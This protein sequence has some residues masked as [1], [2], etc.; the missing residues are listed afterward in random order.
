MFAA[1]PVV[2]I[3]YISLFVFEKLLNIA[4]L[5]SFILSVIPYY[6][7]ILFGF[8]V[9]GGAHFSKEKKSVLLGIFAISLIYT[10]YFFL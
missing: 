7:F 4:M 5:S 8:S 9:E 3:S 2:V 10:T 6:L 1:V